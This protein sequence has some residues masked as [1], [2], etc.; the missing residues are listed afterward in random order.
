MKLLGT[1]S[2]APKRGIALVEVCDQW[3][4]IGIGSENVSLISKVDRP[5]GGLQC[6]TGSMG[7]GTMFQSILDNIGLSRKSPDITDVN[8]NVR[9]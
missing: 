5:E 1:L 7:G 6:N 3:F 4:V 8:Q 2:L 9:K